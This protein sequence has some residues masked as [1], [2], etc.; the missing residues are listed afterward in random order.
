MRWH[1]LSL[2]TY[3]LAAL[4]TPLAFATTSVRA[5][6]A[7]EGRVAIYTGQP[8]GDGFQLI[9]T[10]HASGDRSASATPA[11]E[12]HSFELPDRYCVYIAIWGI[13]RPEAGLI[14]QFNFNGMPVYSGDDAWEV[15]ASSL[16]LGRDDDPPTPTRLAHEILAATHRF[17]WKRAAK[18]VGNG[19]GPAGWV[20]GVDRVAA[21]MWLPAISSKTPAQK[22]APTTMMI[23]RIIPSEVWPEI[24]MSY[25]SSVGT[26]S[27]TGISVNGRVSYGGVGGGGGGGGGGGS[28][29]LSNGGSSGVYGP[30]TPFNTFEPPNSSS[31]VAISPPESQT[32]SPIVPT[33]RD[34]TPVSSST[35]NSSFPGTSTTSETVTKPNPPSEPNTP[36]IP[37]P[38][39]PEPA[40]LALMLLAAGVTRR[41]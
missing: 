15:Y 17:Q 27:S 18:L 7:S 12:Q 16:R 11:S 38:S 6:V 21:W 9:A 39:V 23:F 20:E 19:A 10:N 30:L 35:P 14:G 25:N 33:P 4:A 36:V 5:T 26:P 37:P 22:L 2:S 13:E 8:N 28:G 29:G 1:N 41:R 24:E 3:A 34:T 31:T 40:S 32:S